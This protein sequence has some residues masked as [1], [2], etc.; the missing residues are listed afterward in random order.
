MDSTTEIACILGIPA[1]LGARVLFLPRYLFE[2][3]SVLQNWSQNEYARARFGP[4]YRWRLW[5]LFDIKQAEM[6]ENL[7]N[8]GSDEEILCMRESQLEQFR[9]V[10]LVVSQSQVHVAGWKLCCCVCQKL[11]PSRALYSP[12]QLFKPSV[13]HLF[14]RLILLHAHASHL[15]LRSA[16]WLPFLLASSNANSAPHVVQL[17]CELGYRT[18]FGTGTIMATMFIRVR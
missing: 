1:R 6:Y 11:I 16:Y 14:P 5:L 2:G 12:Q 3:F 13:F 10:A 17:P 8:E 18:V 7:I 15:R 9:L 4:S